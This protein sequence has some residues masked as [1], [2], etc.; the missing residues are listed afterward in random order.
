MIQS[1]NL[2][3]PSQHDRAKCEVVAVDKPSNQFERFFTLPSPPLKLPLLND[4][5]SGQVLTS[6]ECLKKAD[7]V[8]KKLE[9][10]KQRQAK[11][12][13]MLIYS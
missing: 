6:A 13:S 2:L 7:A 9:Q 10:Q 5:G 1:S 12:L 4:K 11:C 8:L 3:T